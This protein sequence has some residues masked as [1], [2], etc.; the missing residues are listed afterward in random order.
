MKSPV[1]S[2][3]IAIYNGAKTIGRCI[4]SI[5]SQS[6]ESFEIIVVDDG[7]SDDTYEI[8]KSY[9]QSDSRIR[10]LKNIKN[11]GV[12]KAR[13]IGVQ[14]SKGKWVLF[15]DADDT[16]PKNALQF[17][18][19]HA[20]EYKMLVAGYNKVAEEKI[21]ETTEKNYYEGSYPAYNM[22]H[23][24]FH[25]RYFWPGYV[26]GKCFSLEVIRKNGIC[27]DEK[28]SRT[29]DCLFC[30]NYLLHILKEN[31]FFS[32]YSVYNY[33]MDEN[34]ATHSSE[35]DYS[36]KRLT[37]FDAYAKMYDHIQDA[38]ISDFILLFNVRRWLY[39]TYCNVVAYCKRFKKEEAIKRMTADLKHRI[40]WYNLLL[41]KAI[42]KI[43]E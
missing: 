32:T 24:L 10:L 36:P 9:E 42:Y 8:C 30:V 35:K 6:F 20:V 1:F 31:I 26:W 28:V 40:P 41:I 5:I 2:I 17:F 22:L 33:Y 34:S 23:D 38:G 39:V 4:E 29:E 25:P 16:L 13:N 43:K 21:V 7:S 18:A 37:D 19:K 14:E 11:G 12:S 27:F 15:V 3:I